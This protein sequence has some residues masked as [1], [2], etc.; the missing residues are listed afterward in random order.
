MDFKKEL[1]QLVNRHCKENGSDTP[2]YILATYLL[3]CLDAF[4][5]AVRSRENW[6][7]RRP[8]TSEV[9]TGT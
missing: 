8:L 1:V 2:D 9:T 6:Y 7:G 5:A 3:D 4:E